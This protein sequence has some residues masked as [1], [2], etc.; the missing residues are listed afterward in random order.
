M[1]ALMAS[2]A[3]LLAAFVY[4]LVVISQTKVYFDQRD[5]SRIVDC[6]KRTGPKRPCHPKTP[7]ADAFDFTIICVAFAFAAL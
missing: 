4:G 2:P 5:P 1:V 3:L 7:D 6:G